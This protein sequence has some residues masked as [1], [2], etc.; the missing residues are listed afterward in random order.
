MFVEGRNGEGLLL[1]GSANMTRR[2]LENFSLETS[3]L[4]RTSCSSQVFM[5]AQKHFDLLW[6]N[7]QEQ[8]FTVPYEH[9][10][11]ESVVKRYSYRFMEASGWCTF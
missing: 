1:L 4:V 5:D 7:T 6:N 2:S 3:V 11:D 8:V 10:Q 9:Y